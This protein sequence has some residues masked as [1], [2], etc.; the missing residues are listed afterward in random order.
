MT[1]YIDLCYKLINYFQRIP[2]FTMLFQMWKKHIQKK[3]KLFGKKKYTLAKMKKIVKKNP[4]KKTK[5]KNA[6]CCSQF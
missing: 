5:K 1:H 3:K 2:F 6:V 4:K